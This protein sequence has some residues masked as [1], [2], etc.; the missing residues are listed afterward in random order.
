MSDAARWSLAALAAFTASLAGVLLVERYAARLGLV[1]LP[2]TRSSHVNPR[3]R[4]GGLGIVLGVFVGAAVARSLA[5]EVDA[6]VW[7]V[8]AAASL[9]AIVG[10]WDDVRGLGIASRLVVQTGAAIAVTFTAGGFDRVPL[11]PPLDVPLGPAW[12]IVTVVWLV[13]VTNFFNFM[14][15]LDGLAAGQA[16]ITFASFAAVAWPESGAAIAILAACATIAFLLRNWSPARIFLGDVGSSFLGFLL[17]AL[18]LTPRNGASAS[19]LVLLVGTSLALFLL[20]PV[21]TLVLRARRGSKLGASHRQHAYQQFVAPSAS[22]AAVVT[23]L[24]VVAGALSILAVAATWRPVLAWPALAVA[25]IA[26]T[27]EWRLAA[28]RR[29]SSA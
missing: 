21:A 5:L 1:D 11:P 12:S 6:A 14:D 8:L 7:I 18:P 24:L 10:L 17:A 16:I 19:V 22:H 4:G 13:G 9:V 26:F 29:Q 3:P 20:D 2:N 28:P 15:G 23:K 27:I 25:A